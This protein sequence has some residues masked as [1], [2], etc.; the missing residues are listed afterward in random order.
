[1]KT[2]TALAEGEECKHIQH[3]TTP[4]TKENIPMW[5]KCVQ[6]LLYNESVSISDCLTFFLVGGAD[7]RLSRVN[8]DHFTKEPKPH[9]SN[10]LDPN[11]PAFMS[12]TAKVD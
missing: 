8:N 1:M 11:T 6:H 4:N 9:Q 12:T 7:C 2:Q 3:F 5:H 10:C